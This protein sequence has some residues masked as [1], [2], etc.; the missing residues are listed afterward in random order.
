MDIQLNS[1][2]TK[3]ATL[4]ILFV[5]SFTSSQAGPLNLSNNALEVVNNVEPNIMII[6]DDSGSMDWGIMTN[7][8]DEGTFHLGG[9]LYYYTHPDPGASGVPPAVNDD[10]YI[11]PTEE[12]LDSQGVAAPQGGVWRAWNH[13]YN[14]MYYNPDIT[15]TPWKGDNGSGTPFTNVSATAAPYDPNLPAAGTFDLTTTTS[16]GTDCGLLEC[17]SLVYGHQLLPRPLLHLG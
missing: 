14:K 2:L 4:A 7:E 15:Y 9:N 13:N 1:A 8:G 10:T 6:H 5:A 17:A 12:Y 3:A 11:V 16:Y